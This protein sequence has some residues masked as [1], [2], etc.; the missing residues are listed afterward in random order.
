MPITD[1]VTV[2]GFYI[3]SAGL[4]EDEYLP[5][6]PLRV[7]FGR[8]GAGKSS[9][10]AGLTQA[11]FGLQTLSRRRISA[12]YTGAGAP[13]PE[14]RLATGRSGLILKLQ[15]SGSIPLR[16][17]EK[18]EFAAA[19]DLADSDVEDVAEHFWG[20]QEEFNQRIAE[21]GLA[22]PDNALHLWTLAALIGD[23]DLADIATG[24]ITYATTELHYPIES[25]YGRA[26]DIATELAGGIDG[27]LVIDPEDVADLRLVTTAFLNSP[28]VLIAS[29]SSMSLALDPAPNVAAALVRLEA[30]R[31]HAESTGFFESGPTNS[32]GSIVQ[33]TSSLYW[34][35]Q[36]HRAS[37]KRWL[38]NPSCRP[39]V[40]I[41]R[42]DEFFA[43]GL[44]RTPIRAVDLGGN[45][46]QT[47]EDFETSLTEAMPALHDRLLRPLLIHVEEAARSRLPEDELAVLLTSRLDQVSGSKQGLDRWLEQ[48]TPNQGVE[49]RHTIQ[50]CCSLLSRRAN[51]L[52]PD[53]LRDHGEVRVVTLPID[54][55]PMWGERRITIWLF[56]DGTNIPL[57]LAASGVRRW[58]LAVVDWAYQE[59]LASRIPELDGI[60][61][62]ISAGPSIHERAEIVGRLHE[63][64]VVPSEQAGIIIVDEPELHLDPRAQLQVAGWFKDLSREGTSVVLA[65][66]SPAFLTYRT[67]EAT[68]TGVIKAAGSITVDD[69]STSLLDWCATYG[70]Q[71]GL[72]NADTI[73]LCAGFIVVEGPHD[74]KVLRKFFWSELDDARIQLLHLYGTQGAPSL[75][76]SEYLVGLG[77]PL[78]I[79]F[80]NI[81]KS[82]EQIMQE[83]RYLTNEE[84]ALKR[85]RMALEQK[86]VHP[87]IG[88]HPYPDVMCALPEEAVRQAFPKADF[89]GWE[90]LEARH[91]ATQKARSLN[92]KKF[93]L[94]EMGLATTGDSATRF[95]DEVLGHCT[96]DAVPRQGLQDAVNELLAHLTNK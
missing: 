37:P 44:D 89:P 84:R 35:A 41:S 51:E 83:D 40:D 48:V 76:D 10:L 66:H 43:G 81:R 5:L 56:Q 91:S 94:G 42:R 58:V 50:A 77:K 62:I 82:R 29:G 78:G 95:I 3:E 59:L 34:I 4:I 30:S 90:E 47:V 20:L 33:P 86:G 80:D 64:E 96:E 67:H 46:E 57:E 63:C 68:L 28:Y 69:M 16:G 60:A 73:L 14:D 19:S 25:L 17:L 45:L 12:G 11:C 23:D 71:V 7:L 70:E 22:P 75:I 26:A 54:F 32:M 65:S 2:E 55:W 39:E 52:M 36:A 93:A 9:I 79:L 38:L 74:S 6:V 88:G 8:S 53:F 24:R 13:R 87:E 85:I 27:A 49:V 72:T 21:A 92:F 15:D 61:A 18:F 1:D 31:R